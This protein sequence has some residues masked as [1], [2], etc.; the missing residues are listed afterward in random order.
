MFVL[1]A[2]KIGSMVSVDNADVAIT[3]VPLGFLSVGVGVG[4]GVGVSV[5]VGV[6]G[7]VSVGVGVS[8]VGAQALVKGSTRANT[9]TKQIPTSTLDN[10]NLRLFILVSSLL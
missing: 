3:T 7:G 4:I 10:L 1:G 2:H 8:G 9:S 6:G 5:G